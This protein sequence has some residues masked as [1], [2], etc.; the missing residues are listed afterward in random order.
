MSTRATYSFDGKHTPRTTVYIHHDGYPEGAAV[1]FYL[2]LCHGGHGRLVE[3]FIR[4]NDRAEIT[5]NHGHHGDTDYRY[6]VVGQGPGATVRVDKCEHIETGV[7]S[8]RSVWTTICNCTLAQFVQHHRATVADWTGDYHP[9]KRVQL[10]YSEKWLNA[11]TAQ[12]W[13]DAEFGGLSTLETWREHG[14]EG[15]ANWRSM[16]EELRAILTA[17]PELAC[18][19]TD[20]FVTVIS[21]NE[22]TIT[23]VTK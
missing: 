23:G 8:Y 2:A 19:R 18:E 6:S 16:I 21:S 14:H 5:T 17:F 15:S 12:Q 3:R 22:T 9:F 10:A 20:Q 7:H 4:A 1:Y 11:K 13:L